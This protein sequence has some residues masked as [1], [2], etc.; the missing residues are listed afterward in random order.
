VAAIAQWASRLQFRVLYR[1]LHGINSYYALTVFWLYVAA[2][3]VTFPFVFVFPPM[4]LLMI[5]LA[6]LCLGIVVVL[7]KVLAALENLAVRHLVR[8]GTCPHCRHASA[9]VASTGGPWV[10]DH[11]GT[12]FLMPNTVS[13]NS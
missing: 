7:A 4:P 9:P 1:I 6:I 11:C 2:F 13:T 12:V 3:A 8:R 5:F 10:C